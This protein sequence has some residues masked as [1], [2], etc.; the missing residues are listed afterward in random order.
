MTSPHPIFSTKLKKALTKQREERKG[1]GGE[2]KEGNEAVAKS[3]GKSIIKIANLLEGGK[4]EDGK[5]T[6]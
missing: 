4:K 3:L 5:K 1:G 2:G 6:P